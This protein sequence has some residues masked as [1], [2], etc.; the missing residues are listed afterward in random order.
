MPKICQKSRDLVTKMN[1]NNALTGRDKIN[2]PSKSV[3]ESHE[4]H[5]MNTDERRNKNSVSQLD[6]IDSRAKYI[7]PKKMKK[8]SPKKMFSTLVNKDK[9]ASLER[10]RKKYEI[11]PTE[12]FQEFWQN[13]QWWQFEHEAKQ[14]ELQQD[15]LK[16]LKK[17]CPFQ[18]KIDKNS[19]QIFKEKSIDGDVSQRN[20]QFIER[21]QA[22]LQ[23]IQKEVEKDLKF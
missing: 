16:K 8:K 6:I 11:K 20:E 2:P 12:G 19:I 1:K 5:M 7:S 4:S 22:K 3:L 13:S 14:I 21:K 9:M 10:V 17:Q 23:K 15:E 18:P